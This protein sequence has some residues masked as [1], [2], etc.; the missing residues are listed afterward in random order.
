VRAGPLT[1]SP[2]RPSPSPGSPP[3]RKIPWGGRGEGALRIGGAAVALAIA[4]LVPLLPR[5]YVSAAA[6]MLLFAIV[7]MGASLVIQHLDLPSIGHAAFFGMAAYGSGLLLVHD[8]A[9]AP[10]ALLLGTLLAAA[11]AAVVGVV[12]LRTQAAAFM[13]ISIAVSQLLSSLAQSLTGITGGD[14]GLTGIPDQTILALDLGDPS[15][16]YFVVLGL[17]AAVVALVATLAASPFGYALHS[18]A[19]GSRQ[20][21]SLGVSPLRTRLVAFVVSAALTGLAGSLYALHNGY[22]DPS[23][24]STATSGTIF[25]MVALARRLGAL[26][27]VVGAV[28][29]EFILTV[30][31]SF[32]THAQLVLGIVGMLAA[33][34][35]TVRGRE[36]RR[37]ARRPG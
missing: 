11:L 32:T 16:F 18:L 2:P 36:R 28:V 10:L 8:V 33:L 7:A 34:L 24:L 22:T 27:P 13:M 31:G 21:S 5:F 25:L 35:L 12:M 19:R 37:P 4:G 29:V 20:A 15:T 30:V 1:A 3:N 17:L 9:A 23:M 6:E 14:N 26:G